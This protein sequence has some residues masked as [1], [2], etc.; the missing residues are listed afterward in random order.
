VVH[1]RLLPRGRLPVGHPLDQHAPR[2]SRRLRPR[3]LRAGDDTVWPDTAPR[4]HTGAAGIRGPDRR[5]APST[6][7]RQKPRQRRWSR[8]NTIIRVD[9]AAA[10]RGR[11]IAGEICEV[12]GT[13]PIP[14]SGVESVLAEGSRLAIVSTNADGTIVERVAHVR[15]DRT[16]EIDIRDP[17]ALYDE[18]V[19]TGR[20]VAE[21]V[22]AGRRP[23][24][25]QLTALQWISPT[26][27]V[28]GCTNLT[29]DVDH[30]T[31]Y[32]VTKD[33][34]LGD[35]DPLC[36]YHHRIK[37]LQGWALVPGRGKRPFVAPDDP[38]HPRNQAG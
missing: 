15:S 25:H 34:K 13:G 19:R 4:P 1:R 7:P 29:C 11:P 38:S 21:D 24:A 32:S 3:P 35:L 2:D 30:E 8:A 28:E 17:Q 26:C 37:T 20:D 16:S 18:L 27:T 6:A 10:E 33:T 14:I 12:A 9:A 5:D 22:H 31:G 23:N 36:R